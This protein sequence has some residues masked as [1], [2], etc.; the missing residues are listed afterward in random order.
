MTRVEWDPL[1]FLLSISIRSGSGR[2]PE[3]GYQDMD[4]YVIY[5][6][7]WITVC[8]FFCIC[9]RFLVRCQQSLSR[10]TVGLAN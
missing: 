5:I 3:A 10:A 8:I 2:T 9:S 4:L 7:I 1:L 6:Y